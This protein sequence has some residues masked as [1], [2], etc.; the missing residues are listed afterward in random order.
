MLPATQPHT[1]TQPRAAHHLAFLLARE[2]QLVLGLAVSL[3]RRLRLA[4]HLQQAP[5]L[6]VLLRAARLT[7][8]A[9]VR[10]RGT[11]MQ[12]RQDCRAC[13]AAIG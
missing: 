7:V 10:C 6:G 2:R 13:S 9:D 5:L 8:A 11:C 1:H 4:L 3:L 12:G